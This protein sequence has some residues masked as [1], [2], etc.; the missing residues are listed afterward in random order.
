[1]NAVAPGA[2]D[3]PF[4]RDALA[5]VPDVDEVLTQIAAAHPLGRISDPDEIAETIVF[6]ASPRSRFVSGAILMV[7]GGY[8]AQ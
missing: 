2:I 8:T 7:D 5:G 1:M 4:L 3:T 6:L